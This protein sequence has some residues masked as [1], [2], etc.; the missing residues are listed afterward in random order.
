M[1]EDAASTMNWMR[2]PVGI[3]VDVNKFVGG[4]QHVR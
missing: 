2:V 4:Q 1:L 3:S